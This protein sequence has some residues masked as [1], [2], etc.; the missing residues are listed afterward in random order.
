VHEELTKRAAAEEERSAEEN[1][2]AILDLL[3][4]RGFVSQGDGA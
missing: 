1:V 4:R 2:R 3:I